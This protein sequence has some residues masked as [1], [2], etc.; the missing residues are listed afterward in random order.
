M[1]GYI[2]SIE[3]FG[4]VDGPGIRFV[5]FLQGCP[6]RCKFCHNPD[7]WELGQGSEMSADELIDAYMKNRAFY[8]KGGITVSG[9]E[10]LM[11]LDFITELFTKAKRYDIHTCIDTSGIT[12]RENDS[13]YDKR[14][15]KLIAVTDL[16]MLDIKHIDPLKHKDLTGAENSSILAFAKFLEKTNV[17]LCIRHVVID[18]I[19][20]N[21]D[22][23]KDLGRFIGKLKNLRYLDVL[24]Y[25][26]LGV[27]KYKELGLPNPLEGIEPT[28]KENAIKAKAYIMEGIKEARSPK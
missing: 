27:S 26:T 18:G 6:L 16:I 9:G 23:L 8:S 10:P 22:D 21:A 13:E 2:H 1:K 4:T 25:H 20:D 14:L 11:Q 19:T 7:T 12:Y 28:T 3:S 17:E 24:P 15:R 5:I